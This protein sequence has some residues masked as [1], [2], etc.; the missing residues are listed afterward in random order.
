MACLHAQRLGFEVRWRI[1]PIL[2][3]SGWL[4]AYEEFFA[5]ASGMGIHPRYITLGTYRQ[6]T[7]QL[8]IWR[9]KWGLPEM[10]WEP[11]ALTKEGTHLHVAEEERIRIYSIVRDL[12]RQ[13]LPEARVSLCKETHSVRKQLQLCNA[14]CNCLM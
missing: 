12:A 5:E 13:H 1:D 8:D 2:T 6:K 10:E 7:P 4:H 14:D 11:T 3:P 9:A